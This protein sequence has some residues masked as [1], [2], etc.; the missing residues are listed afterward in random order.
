MG[1]V[2]ISYEFLLNLTLPD[3]YGYE[4]ILIEI[5]EEIKKE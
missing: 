1:T 4:D 5:L 2:N 3:L